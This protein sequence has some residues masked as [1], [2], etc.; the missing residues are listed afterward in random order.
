MLTTPVW[1][2]T[3]EFIDE[4]SRAV[5]LRGGSHYAPCCSPETCPS[6]ASCRMGSG[7]DT[8]W[9]FPS[10]PKMR[11]LDTHG[12]YHLMSDSYERAGT[13]GFRCAA[14]VAEAAEVG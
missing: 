13:V 6:G 12:Y 2:F 4:H 9:Y 7:Q 8:N 3:D 10:G 1:Q 11:Q 14:D 5:L